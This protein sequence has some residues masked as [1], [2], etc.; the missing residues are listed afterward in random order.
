VNDFT[1]ECWLPVVG[2][3]GLYEVSDMGRVRSIDRWVEVPGWSPYLK[4]GRLLTPNPSTNGYLKVTLCS[5]R[6]GARAQETPAVHRLV[7]EAF[8]GPCPPGQEARHGPGGKQD[9]RL[10]NLTYGTKPENAGDKV[11][12]G[13][14]IHG[15]ISVHARLTE[16]IVRECRSRYAAKTATTVSLAAE[17][18]V[19]QRAMWMVVN[20]KTWKHVVP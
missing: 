2:Y 8:R 13:T 7:L 20:R 19:S 9:N 16:Q 12:D 4:R 3:E 1:H 11:R 6:S 15:T 5:N 18:G 14:H 10:V 17:F